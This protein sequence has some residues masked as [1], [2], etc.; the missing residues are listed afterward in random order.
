MHPLDEHHSQNHEENTW[1]SLLNY[2]VK[3]E[4]MVE[5]TSCHVCSLFPRSAISTFLQYSVEASI[6]DTLCALEVI[7]SN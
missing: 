3:T 6:N 2:T 1:W 5:N 7:L 4:L